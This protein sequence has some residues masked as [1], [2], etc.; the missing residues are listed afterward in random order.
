MQHSNCIT[1]LDMDTFLP[2]YKHM[3]PAS[4]EFK[5]NLRITSPKL[6]RFH[7]KR[8]MFWISVTISEIWR[9][10]S[11]SVTGCCG[12]C[13]WAKM[14]HCHVNTSMLPHLETM[15]SYWHYGD[16]VMGRVA[17]QITSLTIVYST[18]CSDASP[19]KWPVARKMFPFDDVIMVRGC[20]STATE[21]KS[22][23]IN[24][25]HRILLGRLV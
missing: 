19:H 12:F 18:V 4:H 3:V 14:A 9:Y 2:N 11:A 10:V 24:A 22:S 17:S 5:P 7:Q 16:V 13:E 23:Y 6:C 25:D 20:S 21:G 1:L 8:D 15:E